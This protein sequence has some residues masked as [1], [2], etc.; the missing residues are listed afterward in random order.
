[1]CTKT[2]PSKNKLTKHLQAKNTYKQKQTNKTKNK[3]TKNK[4]NSFLRM[5]KLKEIE[6]VCLLLVLFVLFVRVESFCKKKAGLK[7]S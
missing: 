1:M 2:L 3:H 7:L 6:I 4:S 5:Q